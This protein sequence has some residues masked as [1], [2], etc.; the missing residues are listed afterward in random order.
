M[1]YNETKIIQLLN[2]STQLDDTNLGQQITKQCLILFSLWCK[3][4]HYQL[5]KKHLSKI[6]SGQ[7]VW[8]IFGPKLLSIL[9]VVHCMKYLG[10]NMSQINMLQFAILTYINEL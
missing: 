5:K 7:S 9:L 6:W 8:I 4:L 10:Y 3:C 2:L 1:D